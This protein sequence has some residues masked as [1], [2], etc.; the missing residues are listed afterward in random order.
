MV[1]IEIKLKSY[2]KTKK[3]WRK[4]CETYQIPVLQKPPSMPQ[5]G[6]EVHAS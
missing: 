6:K 2:K 4:V 5:Y 1:F 3:I